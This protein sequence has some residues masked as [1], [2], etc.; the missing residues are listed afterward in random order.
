MGDWRWVD[1]NCYIADIL[2]RGATPEELSEE[3]DL[4]RGP[5]FW[6]WPETNWPVKK[7]SEITSSAAEDVLKLRR[8]AF[9][10][11]VTR[12]H[13]KEVTGCN[14]P[15][16]DDKNAKGERSLQTDP[17][18]SSTATMQKKTL[19]HRRGAPSGGTKVQFSGEAMWNHCLDSTSCRSLAEETPSTG[20]AKVGGR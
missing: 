5:E 16:I 6:K 14:Y 17:D 3:T 9:S 8:K 13:L 2:T 12:A 4:Q 20:P 15:D 18:P 11:V 10:A 1:G 7:V 19:E